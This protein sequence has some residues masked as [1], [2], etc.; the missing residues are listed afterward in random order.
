MQLS[1]TVRF[2]R[3]FTAKRVCQS[4]VRCYFNLQYQVEWL[5]QIVVFFSFSML[6]H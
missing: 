3:V 2:L 4:G 1:A 5:V 6:R